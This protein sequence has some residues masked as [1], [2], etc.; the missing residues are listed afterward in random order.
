[1]NE[2]QVEI[3]FEELRTMMSDLKSLSHV[4]RRERIATAVLASLI[5]DPSAG[6]DGRTYAEDAIAFADSLIAELDKETNQ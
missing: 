5:L 4:T 3:L 1:M 2:R 6:E